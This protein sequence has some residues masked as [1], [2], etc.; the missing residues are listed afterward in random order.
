MT[1]AFD[2]LALL[3]DAALFG[4][5]LAGP[6]TGLSVDSRTVKPGHLFAAL[7]GSLMHGASFAD[8]AL[9]MGAVAILTDSE[10]LAQLI[11]EGHGE[12][13]PVIV[14]AFPR[15]AL[16]R[17]AAR[18]FA[19]QPDVMVAVTGTNGKSSVTSFLRQ[20]WQIAGLRAVNLGTTGVEGS[21]AR[22]LSHTTPEPITLHALLADLAGDR[23]SHAAIEASSHGLDQH[24]LDGVRLAAAGFTHLSRDHLDYHGTM[25]AYAEAKLA[26]FSRVLPQG[27]PAVINIDDPTAKRAGEIA[28]D[29]GCPVIRVGRQAGANLRLIETAFTPNGQ[30]LTVEHGG[31]TRRFDLPL[32]G[33]F[34]GENVLLAAGLALATGVSP[35][36]TFAALPQLHGVRG[37]MEHAATR[38]NGAG[39]FVDYSHTPDSLATALKALRPH[40]KGRLIAVFGAGGDRDPGKRPLM[41][42]A[43]A[44]FADVAIL[45]DDNPRSEDPALIRAAVRP[46][47]PDASEVGDRAEAILAGVDALQP[48][49]M[50]LI[51]G[52]GQ[53]TGQIIGQEIHPFNDRAQARAAVEALDGVM[54]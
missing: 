29:R 1:D 15:A 38:S 26:L 13:V 16:A 42:Q 18:W 46:G 34:Q 32:I 25:E 33:G 2:V 21:V 9:R 35:K 41:G 39:V 4:P 7:P 17:A 23:V 31:E 48:G 22:A 51:A 8:P 49:D 3:E 43:A 20:I 11:A 10:G 6:L 30:T 5:G 37:R 14:S 24:R 54:P 27:A 28:A 50:L 19:A 45:T 53:E 12:R 44:A 36:T 40:T 52:K 47:C